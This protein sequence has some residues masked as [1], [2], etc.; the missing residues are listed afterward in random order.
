MMPDRKLRILISDDE[1]AMQALLRITLGQHGFEIRTA[2]TGPEA[3]QVAEEFEPDLVLMD[4]RMPGAFDG[5][6]ATRRIPSSA[7]RSSSARP[8]WWIWAKSARTC[9]RAL[10]T[11]WASRTCRWT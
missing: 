11:T 7:A 9:R 8:G 4:I 3:V 5:T 2:S 10:T 6:E 1:K